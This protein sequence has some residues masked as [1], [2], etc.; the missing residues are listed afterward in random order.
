VFLENFDSK[1]TAMPS[2]IGGETGQVPSPARRALR[3][4]EALWAEVLKLASAVETTLVT[5]IKAL[6]DGRP[7]L[8]AEVKDQERLIDRW[9]V[10]IEQEC[11]RILALYDPTASDLRRMVTA[12]KVNDDLER[13]ADLAVSIAKKARKLASAPTSVP[14]PEPL[15]A[16]TKEVLSAVRDSLD[17]LAQGDTEAAR[18]VIAADRQ[19]NRKRQAMLRQ[20]KQTIRQ[21]P[22]RAST[23]LRMM[24]TTRNLDR[25]ADHARKIAVSVIYMKEGTIVRHAEGQQPSG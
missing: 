10:Q 6:T 8:A 2:E 9:E 1:E 7:D 3:D 5:S 18:A 20:L 15:I 12:L 16:L 21:D 19:I 4:Q 13:M 22:D 14:I 23:W 11:L 24:S 17:A 25:I